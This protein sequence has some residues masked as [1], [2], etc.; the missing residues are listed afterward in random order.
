MS[1]DSRGIHGDLAVGRNLSAGGDATVRGDMSVG[2]GLR[3]EG[4][5]DAPNIVHAMKG[6]FESLEDLQAAYPNPEP[7]WIALVGTALPA[8]IYIGT[9]GERDEPAGCPCQSGTR[10]GYWTATG[11]VGGSIEVPLRDIEASLSELRQATAGNAESIATLND[12]LT[13]QGKEIAD[14]GDKD[15]EQ[16][17]AIAALGPRVIAESELDSMGTDG[18]PASIEALLKEGYS[19]WQVVDSKG[20][21]TG[22]LEMFSDNAGHVLTQVLTTHYA[23]GCL[24]GKYEEGNDI[25]CGAH[26][27][28]EIY[29][30]YRSMAAT[31][32]TQL[33]VERG[34]W[35]AWREAEPKGCRMAR[36]LMQEAINGLREDRDVC[37]E[38]IGTLRAEL[39]QLREALAA[40]DANFAALRIEWLEDAESGSWSATLPSRIEKEIELRLSVA[41]N[42]AMQSDGVSD[43]RVTRRAGD[44]AADKAWNDRHPLTASDDGYLYIKLSPE[45]ILDSTGTRF[46][47]TALYTRTRNGVSYSQSVEGRLVLEMGGL[48]FYIDRGV[49]QTGTKYYNNQL[50]T[51]GRLETSDAWR[52]GNKWRSETTHTATADNGPGFG[53]PMWTFLEGD[54]Q[55]HVDFAE[56]VSVVDLN[57]IELP[58]TLTARYHG[59]D[60]LRFIA[61]SDVVWSRYS[62]T[63]AGE[64]RVEMDAE[65]N[66]ANSGRGKAPVFR[67]ADFQSTG[68]EGLG[69]ISF[70]A[71]VTLRDPV[72]STKVRGAKT[73]SV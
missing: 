13:A 40:S 66:A 36:T 25:P 48:V 2:H 42:G 69:R 71:V 27:D 56:P 72:S 5:L 34:K 43:W 21:A 37:M 47:F 24:Q 1:M 11:E 38:E 46:E 44:T 63:E 52:Y 10:R 30:Y 57:N 9:A 33:D 23:L 64:P 41:V 22:A 32:G 8:P 62:E 14:L 50:N 60:V 7:G 39:T 18:K 70:T 31:A 29:R 67:E 12:D 19:V 65:W 54:D 20:H 28:G 68:S 45:D 59:E 73:F 16:D 35:S 53:N 55:F 49:W 3:V 58:L 26:S 17:K 4:W 51:E 6:L 61:D 15:K